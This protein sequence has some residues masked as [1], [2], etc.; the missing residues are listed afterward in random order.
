MISIGSAPMHLL[1]DAS[2]ALFLERLEESIF[3]F[4]PI[5]RWFDWVC[6]ANAQV[7]SGQAT[8]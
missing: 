7:T 1:R 2:L 3:P 8:D 5:S 4:L 6:E